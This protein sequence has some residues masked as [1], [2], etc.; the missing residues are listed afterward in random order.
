VLD[1]INKSADLVVEDP[2]Q[3]FVSKKAPTEPRE[4]LI[5]G[6]HSIIYS[7]RYYRHYNHY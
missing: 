6:M 7:A 3:Q 2:A 5:V 4:D 1:L